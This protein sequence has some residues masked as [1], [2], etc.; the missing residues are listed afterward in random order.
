[1]D[2]DTTK[3]L[4][5][6]GDNLDALKLLQ[7]TYL[8]RVGMSSNR[9]VVASENLRAEMAREYEQVR[10][11]AL[12]DPRVRAAYATVDRRLEEKILQVD[13]VLRGYVSELKA[14]KTARLSDAVNYWAQGLLNRCDGGRR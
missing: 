3:N 11:I 12:R 5:I 13:P 14:G 6:E 10:K 7:E 2:F 1:V 4:F 9:S 8:G